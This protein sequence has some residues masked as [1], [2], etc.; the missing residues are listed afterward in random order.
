MAGRFRLHR[1]TEPL[2]QIAVHLPVSLK[3]W[4]IKEAEKERRSL[5]QQIVVALEVYREVRE[6]REK[7]DV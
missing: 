4:Y 2:H 6:I 1:A 3:E 7:L 5:N